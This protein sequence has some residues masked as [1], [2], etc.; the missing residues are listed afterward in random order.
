M[1]SKVRKVKM[2]PGNTF[3]QRLE[4]QVNKMAKGGYQLRSSFVLGNSVI[5]VYQL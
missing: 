4:K 2:K 1:A 5:C 3:G